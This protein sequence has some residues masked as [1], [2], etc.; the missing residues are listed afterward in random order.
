MAC[1][2][3]NVCIFLTGL[4]A[5][6]FIACTPLIV[7]Q[8]PSTGS[9]ELSPSN[10]DSTPMPLTAAKTIPIDQ[11]TFL[12]I[13]VIPEYTN[14]S[15]SLNLYTWPENQ[16]ANTIIIRV[17][18]SDIP[19]NTLINKA[20]L[21]LYQYNYNIPGSS[22][23]L[24]DPA[25]EIYRATVQR[26]I[27]ANPDITLAT[28]FSYDATHAWAASSCCGGVPL[29]QGNLAPEIYS[30]LDLDRVAEYKA[31]DITSLIQ[32]W[33]T[34]PSSNL[35]LAISSDTSKYK[36]CFRFFYSSRSADLSKR[37]YVYVE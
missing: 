23:D 11:D 30:S 18:L 15:T 9:A 37:P 2:N 14:S 36:N 4:L 24:N 7:N 31:W 34:L 16:M 3:K 5:V 17:D 12:N 32:T 20:T 6:A 28:G 8:Y 27:N 19:S 21:F 22:C 10:A 25:P 26:I 29:A 1:L 35:G 13:D 33:I